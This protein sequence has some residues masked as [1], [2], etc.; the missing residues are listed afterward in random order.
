MYQ[1]YIV[2]ATEVKSYC[3]EINSEI[4][5]VLVNRAI[6]A[7]EDT[8]LRD[9][10]G[11]AW[12]DEL[13]SQKS[14]GTYSVANKYVIDNFLKQLISFGV[15]EYLVVTLSLQ[16]NSSGLRIKT[17]DHSVQSESKDMAFYRDYIQNYMDRTR[18]TMKR[19]LDLNKTS[20]PLYYSN[21]YHDD[22]KKNIYDFR[23]GKI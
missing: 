11:Q 4:S 23:I 2:T 17:S 19:Y 1:E 7:V 12:S 8:I 14:G 16:L 10:C 22:P 9:S 15:W 6:L 21:T 3:P 13:I 18:K 5:D 20:Y